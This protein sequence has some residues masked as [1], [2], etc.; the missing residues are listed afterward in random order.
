MIVTVRALIL[1]TV[2]MLMMFIA[3]SAQSHEL[4]PAIANLIVSNDMVTGEIEL[5]LEP[6]I[7]GIDLR[8]VENTDDA[9]EASQYDALRK[10]APAELRIMF[11]EAWPNLKSKFRL[12][13]GTTALNIEIDALI[14]PPV[15]NIELTRMAKLS[16][17]AALPQDGTDITFGWAASLGNLIVRQ[18]QPDGEIS[19]ADFLSA[20]GK[21]APM[22]RDGA[23]FIGGFENFVN[24]IKIGFEHI[25]PKGLDHILFVLG[26]F[27]F[28]L[29]MRPLLMQVTAFT[30]AHTVTLAMATTGVVSVPASIV[31]PLI[32]LS[33]AFVALE[34]IKGGDITIRRTA[35]VFAFGLLH[36]LGFASVLGDVGL[37]PSKFISSLIAFN[38]GVELGQLSVIAVAFMTLGIVFGKKSW[39]RSRIAIPGSIII[40]VVGIYWTIERV[41]L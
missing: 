14:I 2:A 27:F 31:E 37:E 18:N 16:F 8:S 29:K 33:I 9:P 4:Q 7:A 23:A 26:L 11:D 40:A 36:G 21:S 13:A 35:I 5:S 1:S 22:P 10:M 17:T 15:G 32:A 3:P 19:Y 38:I 6:I 30:L 12:L 34:N 20:G 28:S 39:Y 41:F 25:I 24:Y